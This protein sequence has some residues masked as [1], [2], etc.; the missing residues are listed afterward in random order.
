MTFKVDLSLHNK[1]KHRD[2]VLKDTAVELT[3]QKD[4]T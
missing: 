1:I 2:S 3:Q 4:M